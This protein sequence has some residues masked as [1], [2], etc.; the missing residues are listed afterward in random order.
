MND[1]SD[2]DLPVNWQAAKT[3]DGHIFY[4][5]HQTKHTQWEHPITKQVNVIS[6]GNQSNDIHANDVHL[7]LFEQIY[8]LAGKKVLI[9]M[10][11]LSTLSTFLRESDRDIRLDSYF[12]CHEMCVN[13]YE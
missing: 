11:I 9:N 8:H 2:D 5:N 10:A 6:Q 3:A 13:E 7:S 12:V 1:E 4:V